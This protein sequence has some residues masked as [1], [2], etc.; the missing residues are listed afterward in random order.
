MS[1]LL[2]LLPVFKRQNSFSRSAVFLREAGNSANSDSHD[3][4]QLSVIRQVVLLR[5]LSSPREPR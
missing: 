5:P 3:D 2:D 4:R 1:L